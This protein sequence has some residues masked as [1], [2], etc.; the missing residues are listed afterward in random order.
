MSGLFRRL[1][2]RRSDGPDGAEPPAQAEQGAADAPA[3]APAEPGGQPSLLVDPAAQ[4]R[5]LGDED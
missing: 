2:S 3:N 1:S 5:V 4:T